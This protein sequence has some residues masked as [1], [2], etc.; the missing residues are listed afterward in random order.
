MI[1]EGG[2]EVQGEMEGGDWQKKGGQKEGG[3]TGI[4]LIILFLALFC[5]YTAEIGWP[6]RGGEER[7]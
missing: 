3:G 5:F 7:G 6:Q 4:F 2:M 1:S